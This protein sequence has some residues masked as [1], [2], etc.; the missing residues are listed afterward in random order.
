MSHGQARRMPEPRKREIDLLTFF[1]EARSI[2]GLSYAFQIAF[3]LHAAGKIAR[4]PIR[5]DNETHNGNHHP[6]SDGFGKVEP[7]QNHQPASNGYGQSN[8]LHD[9]RL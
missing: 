6:A 4:G 2:Y 7:E 3:L 8:K 5:A 1:I 9:C